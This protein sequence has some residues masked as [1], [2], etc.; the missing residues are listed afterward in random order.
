KKKALSIG[1]VRIKHFLAQKL[2][3]GTLWGGVVVRKQ[4]SLPRPPVVPNSKF[5]SKIFQRFRSAKSQAILT[6]PF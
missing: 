1:T 3:L 6:L 2:A 4:N 5:F